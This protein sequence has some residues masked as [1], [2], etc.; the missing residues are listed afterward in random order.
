[1]STSSG[2]ENGG[3]IWKWS[4]RKLP[5]VHPI[6]HD[7]DYQR[8]FAE[9]DGSTPRLLEGKSDSGLAYLPILVKDLGGGLSEAYSA[10]G[11]GGFLGKNCLSEPDIGQ[12][13]TFLAAESVIALFLRHSPFLG[14]ENEVP[15]KF[16]ELNRFSYSVA[17]K[18]HDSLNSLLAS[19]PQKIRWSVNYAQR[20]GVA[21]HFF[22]SDS[23]QTEHL[24]EFHALYKRVMLEKQAAPYYHFSE[25]HFRNHARLLGS[26]CELAI[27][28]EANT[29]KTIGGALFLLDNTL[30]AHYHLSAASPNAMKAQGMDY[31]IA[32][33]M[34][35]Y[36]RAGFRSIHLGGGHMLSEQ[37]GLSK[38]KM[39]FAN[40]RH[41]F[42]CSKIVCDEAAYHHER[43]RHPLR[44]PSLFLVSDAR[45]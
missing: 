24:V 11:Y 6:Y 23:L 27:L 22:P 1:M 29:D 30:R 44:Y 8:L 37:D 31:L 18:R 39:K 21:V 2:Q 20:S 5:D 25:D 33:A 38:F 45:G 36:G 7:A 32:S 43:R 16:R 15:P 14:N 34:Y 42:H 13:T 17:L 41:E 9:Y 3:E 35:R 19:M 4:N 12:L 10:Y 40:E 26:N 28:T